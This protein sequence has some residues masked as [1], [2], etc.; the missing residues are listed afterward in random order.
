MNRGG[1][2][3]DF[4]KVSDARAIQ[5][6]FVDL[7]ESNLPDAVKD[8]MQMTRSQYGLAKTLLKNKGHLSADGRVNSNSLYG[9]LLKK[10]GVRNRADDSLLRMMETDRFLTNRITPSSGTAERLLAN[11]GRVAG[12]VAI[13]AAGAGAIG[14]GA[15]LLFGD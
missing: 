4:A 15:N 11:P 8:S 6:V 2:Q 9:T 12:N 3:G 13:G 1:D 10:Q 7:L 14:T 5:E